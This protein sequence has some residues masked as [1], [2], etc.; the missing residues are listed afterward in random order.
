MRE[1]D[2][3][4][5]DA[6]RGLVV[7]SINR[8]MV[9]PINKTLDLVVCRRANPGSSADSASFADLVQQYGIHLSTQEAA[10]LT[11]CPSVPLEKKGDVNE[12][13]VALEAKACMTK[14]SASI[15]RLHAEILA[16]GYL[17][18][19][20][21]PHCLTVSHTLVNAAPFFMSPGRGDSVNKHSQPGDANS[22]LSM[23]RL[24][25]PRQSESKSFGYDVV[26]AS[27]IDCKNDG[28]PVTEVRGEPSPTS[29][30][31][32]N[33]RQMIAQLCGAYR[34]HFGS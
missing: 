20:A 31:F 1:C 17:A 5:D 18:K 29:S 15:P 23:L 34:K 13:I 6:G 4:R 24:A 12:I 3:F 21:A 28:S 11:K 8:V 25:I 9:G 27:V 30:D 16:T 33:Y 19:Q 14:H 7:V 26:G 22:I 10:A 2:A 32:L